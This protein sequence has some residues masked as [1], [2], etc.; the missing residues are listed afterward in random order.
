MSYLIPDKFDYVSYWT[1]DRFDMSY[2][3][4][5]RFDYMS[6]WTLG[7]SIICRIGH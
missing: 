1:P 5:D 3:I 6:Y 2:W 4:L 7:G